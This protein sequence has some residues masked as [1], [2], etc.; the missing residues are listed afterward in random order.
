MKSFYIL[1]L[2][3]VIHKSNIKYVN[4]ENKFDFSDDTIIGKAS[5]KYSRPNSPQLELGNTSQSDKV[6]VNFRKCFDENDVLILLKRKKLVYDGFIMKK[7]NLK[8]SS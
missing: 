5:I 2:P 3:I 7:V 6:F 8:M 4:E 1:R